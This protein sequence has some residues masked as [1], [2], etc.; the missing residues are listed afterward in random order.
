MRRK[1]FAPSPGGFLRWLGGGRV[2][3]ISFTGPLSTLDFPAFLNF[4]AGSV[5]RKKDVRRW[6]SISMFLW[7]SRC[8]LLHCPEKPTEPRIKTAFDSLYWWRKRHEREFCNLINKT[9]SQKKGRRSERRKFSFILGRPHAVRLQ[10][11]MMTSFHGWAA[12]PTKSRIFLGCLLR[13]GHN[14]RLIA[15]NLNSTH[16][17]LNATFWER[18]LSFAFQWAGSQCWM[19]YYAQ[20]FTVGRCATPKRES[21]SVLSFA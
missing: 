20:C 16:E 1:L 4:L 9:H 6:K 2:E 8:W 13:R 11:I 18:L 10:P 7:R 12:N 15:S 19:F 14:E 17:N 21:N 3:D 5:C